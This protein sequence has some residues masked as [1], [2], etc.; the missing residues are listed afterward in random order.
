MFGSLVFLLMP[1]S[2]H[3][4]V[5][6]AVLVGHAIS[7]VQVGEGLRCPPGLQVLRHAH[8]RSHLRPIENRTRTAM[9]L[10]AASLSLSDKYT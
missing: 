7:V 6:L 2:T 3:M 4:C 9:E 8:G 10:R 1:Q 5:D